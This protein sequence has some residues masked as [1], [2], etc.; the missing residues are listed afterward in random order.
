[1]SSANPSWNASLYDEKHNFVTRYGEGVLD[2]LQVS[3]G[4]RVLDLGCGT[5]HLAA[6][7][8]DK[9]CEV[10]GLDSDP[11]MIKSASASY[12]DI[13]FVLA[14]AANWYSERPFDA[15]FSN[16]AFHWMPDLKA[17]FKSTHANMVPKG[18][19][20]FE[21]GGKD[22]I[23][24]VI[25]SLQVAAFEATGKEFGYLKN[26]LSIGE[27]AQLLEPSGFRIEAAWQFD[28]FTTLEGQDGLRNWYLQF[29]TK[30]LDELPLDTRDS[31][32]DRAEALAAGN[33][34]VNGAWHADYRR[35]RVCARKL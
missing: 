2:L 13:E 3:P 16:A 5:G 11:E 24:V 22:N 7:I 20:V 26:F 31:V 6:K 27:V 15:V 8:R 30:I 1:M 29:A 18:T 17:V 9:G 4:M 25:E 12:P 23:K 32:M 28:R 35:L 34:H 21:M 14:D 19:L 10:V 33:L